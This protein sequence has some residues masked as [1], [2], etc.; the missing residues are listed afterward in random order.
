TGAVTAPASPVQTVRP[1]PAASVVG[2]GFLSGLRDFAVADMGGTTTDVA[3][4]A[5]G[6]PLIRPEGAGVGG[7]RTRAEAVAIRTSAL[8]GDSEVCIDRE[9]QLAVGPRRV[10]PLALLAQQ[11]PQVLP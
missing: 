8:G 9:R 3:I 11:V 10:M 5:G 1:G 6:R 2:A 7:W 4:V